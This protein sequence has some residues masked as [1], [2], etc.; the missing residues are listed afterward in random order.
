MPNFAPTISQEIQDQFASI[1]NPRNLTLITDELEGV[2]LGA[3]P[4][5]IY[6]YSYSPVNESAPLFA[7][8]T[9][10]VFE[11]HKLERGE[12]H[13]LG[14]LTAK[15]AQLVKDGKEPLELRLYPEPRDEST[16]IVSIPLDRMVK[17]RNVSR[18]DGNYMPIQVDAV[19]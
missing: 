14:F 1:R 4:D 9:F 16:T 5:N 17:A 19:L 15:E 8:R 2:G 13:V 18:S 10:Q 7:K 3:L 6:G 11:V 12:V